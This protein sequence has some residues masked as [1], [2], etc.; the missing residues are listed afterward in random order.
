[1]I[2]VSCWTITGERQAARIRAL[3]LKSIL[4]QDIAFFDKDMS[5][6]QVVERMSG[7]TFLIQD[8]IGEKVGCFFSRKRKGIFS[9]H[10]IE[11]IEVVTHLL[12]GTPYGF[13]SWTMSILHWTDDMAFCRSGKV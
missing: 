3:Y 4:R 6:G 2:E 5:T 10:I 8:A 13:K 11:K 1:L 12:R 7:D 9:F